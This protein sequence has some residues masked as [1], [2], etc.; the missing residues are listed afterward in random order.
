MKAT[1]QKT[2]LPSYRIAPANK[3]AEVLRIEPDKAK[4][5]RALIGGEL[6]PEDFKSVQ[7]WVNQCHNPPEHIEKL[8]LA[9]NEVIGGFGVEVVT[10]ENEWVSHFY[11]NIVLEY[12]NLGDTYTPTICFDTDNQTFFLGSWGDYVESKNL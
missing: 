4:Q 12:I 6:N 10:S 11:Q 9:L 8:L 1:E 3:I 5:V 7:K 2:L